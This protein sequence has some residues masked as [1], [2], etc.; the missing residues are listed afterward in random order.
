MRRLP[1][2]AIAAFGLLCLIFFASIP[3]FGSDEATSPESTLEELRDV[4]RENTREDLPKILGKERIPEEDQIAAKKV[5]EAADKILAQDISDDFRI[6]TMKR[7]A[8]ALAVLAYEETSRYFPLLIDEIDVLAGQK[9]CEKITQFT[10][11]HVL[12]IASSLL[13]RPLEK[14]KIDI[15]PAALAEW[16]VDYAKRH[17]GRESDALI[18]RLVAS[19]EQEPL[20]RRNKLLKVVAPMFADYFLESK[21]GVTQAEGRRLRAVARRLNL[22]GKPIQWNATNLDGEPFDPESIKGKVVLVQFWGTWCIPCREEMPGLIDLYRRYQSKGFEI[23][24]VNTCVQG[25]EKPSTVKRFVAETTFGDKKITWPVV[26]DD[27]GPEKNH[28]M[29]TEYYGITF[30]PELILIGRDGKVVKTGLL[31]SGLELDIQNAIS[32]NVTLDDLTPEERA[33]AEA[34]RKLEDEAIR[35]ELESFK[36]SEK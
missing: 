12:Q 8:L 36:K 20:V 9:G 30:V 16:L 14:N 35:R 31:A 19:I 23:V 22:P 4:L 33:Q 25:D 17:P 28:L 10:E 6:W 29:M 18:E 26:L 34:A 11:S 7:R 13:V 21:E 32:P 3:A 5:L 24:G 27:G 2:Q 15:D 1:V